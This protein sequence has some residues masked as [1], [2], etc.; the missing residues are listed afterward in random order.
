MSANPYSVLVVSH[1]A[2]AQLLADRIRR[3]AAEQGIEIAAAARDTQH[4]CALIDVDLPNGD[5]FAIEV[6][7]RLQDV[8]VLD[9]GDNVL[10]EAEVARYAVLRAQGAKPQDAMKLVRG[11]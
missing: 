1:T 11:S 4:D 2:R 7:D 3:S 6:S 8:R 9:P 10:R 5:G